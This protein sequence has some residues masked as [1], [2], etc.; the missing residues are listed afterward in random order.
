M[1]KVL[2]FSLD[3]DIISVTITAYFDDGKL[4][5]EGYDIG[6]FVE[7]AWGDSDYEYSTTINPKEVKKLYPLFEVEEGD[8]RRL[9]DAIKGRYHTNTCYS[10]FSEFLRK[11]NIKSDGFSWT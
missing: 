5:I 10:E 2:L 8:K 7:E 1:Y 6:K 3:S 9:L 4:V 11:N